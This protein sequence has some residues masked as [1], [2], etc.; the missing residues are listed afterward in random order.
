MN[1]K[2]KILTVIIFLSGFY[3]ADTFSQN[4]GSGNTGLTFL[5]LGVSARAIAMGDAFSSVSEDATAY[6]YNPA[7][8]NFGVKSNVILMHNGT[9]QDLYTDYIAVKFPLGEDVSMGIG[10][11]TTSVNDIEIRQIP[12]A[13]IGNFD[14]RNLSTGLSFG[15]KVTPNLS[16]GITG[17]YLYEKIYV[18]EANGLA[19]DFGSNYVKD[20]LSIALVFANIGSMDD[21]KNASSTLPSLVRL[22]G[23]YKGKKDQFSYD[24]ALEG[25][26]VLDG[27]T[28]H[29]NTGGEL[30]YKDFAFL[31]LGYQTSYENR[32]FTTGVGFKYKAVYLDY[33][34]VPF[35][36]DFGTGNS[37]SLGINF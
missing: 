27:G 23:S 13:S 11:F 17:K 37:I 29:L 3:S 28:F 18:D 34:F 14:T 20:N 30:G 31:R 9:S 33:A 22:G 32:G 12:G 1:F 26:K 24:I 19:F 36:N 8:L 25:F 16:L 5:K 7:R 15:Y 21:L 4:D 6:V 2:N 10:F 35:N